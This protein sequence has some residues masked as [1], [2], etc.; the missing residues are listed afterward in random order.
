LN[1]GFWGDNIVKR[2][3]EKWSVESYSPGIRKLAK[4][5]VDVMEE[6]GVVLK[7]YPFLGVAQSLLTNEDH[8]L[9]RCGAGWTNY[10]I[11]TDGYIVPCPT[12][13]GMK[14][15]YLGNIKNSNP[16]KLEKVYLNAPCISCQ[17]IN[18]CGGRCLYANLTK[19]WN[20]KAHESV[21]KTVH[22]LIQTI[23]EQIPRIGKL[24]DDRKITLKDFDYMKYNGCEI[25]P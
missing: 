17:N 18:L 7:L 3:F 21:C 16:L 23:S 20:S 25:I 8:P 2:G 13:W 24:V 4:H 14:D 22:T 10:A 5:W 9:L 12:M 11:Q 15:Y 6:T 1:A 19:R